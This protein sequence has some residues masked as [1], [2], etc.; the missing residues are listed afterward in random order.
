MKWTAAMLSSLS[1][2][3]VI[4]SLTLEQSLDSLIREEKSIKEKLGKIRM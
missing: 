4:E 1:Y 2:S 3:S